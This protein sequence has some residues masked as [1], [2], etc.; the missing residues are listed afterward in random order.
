MVKAFVIAD[1]GQLV[2]ASNVPTTKLPTIDL[3]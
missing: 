1:P 2:F 3:K